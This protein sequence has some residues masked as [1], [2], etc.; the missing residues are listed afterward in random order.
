MRSRGLD[1]G[2]HGGVLVETETDGKSKVNSYSN[3]TTG[4]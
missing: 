2:G 4:F 1:H 3:V